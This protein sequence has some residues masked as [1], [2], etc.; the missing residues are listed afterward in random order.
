MFHRR[1]PF[2]LALTVALAAFASGY[3]SATA[4]VVTDFTGLEVEVSVDVTSAGG[5]GF[6][7]N[8]VGDDTAIIGAGEEFTLDVG[9]S[10]FSTNSVLLDFDGTGLV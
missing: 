9:A 10:G 2:A 7:V 5:Q 1:S 3:N 4:G 6:F 8:L